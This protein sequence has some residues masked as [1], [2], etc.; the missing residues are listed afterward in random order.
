MSLL[1]LL[2]PHQ[3]MY[4]VINNQLMNM[5]SQDLENR[6]REIAQELGVEPELPQ[7]VL[8]S[9]YSTIPLMSTSADEMA[10]Y[11]QGT[12]AHRRYLEG[13]YT[14]TP[15]TT[16]PLMDMSAITP[17]NLNPGNI[18]SPTPYL[19]DPQQTTGPQTV[20]VPGVEGREF[21]IDLDRWESYENV[22]LRQQLENRLLWGAMLQSTPITTSSTTTISSTA[23]PVSQGIYQQIRE[24]GNMVTYNTSQFDLSS[25]IDNGTARREWEERERREMEVDIEEAEVELEGNQVRTRRSKNVEWYDFV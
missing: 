2:R 25:F 14:Q 19:L 24:G 5:M 3:V 7:S 23:Y 9:V 1:D 6:W 18:A 10:A 8:N 13:L 22:Q 12:E 21:T 15:L 20:D 17:I 16:I 4:N 11:R